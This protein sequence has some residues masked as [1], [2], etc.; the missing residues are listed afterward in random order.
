[1]FD[2]GPTENLGLSQLPPLGPVF[3]SSSK[4]T[5]GPLIFVFGQCSHLPPPQVHR[6][7]IKTCDSLWHMRPGNSRFVAADCISWG[8]FSCGR[9]CPSG[10]PR[11]IRAN[12]ACFP[13]HLH[14]GPSKPGV[15]KH[16]LVAPTSALLAVRETISGL[17]GPTPKGVNK[18]R[19]AFAADNA[20]RSPEKIARFCH[21]VARIP[22]LGAVEFY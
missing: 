3:H 19:R 18:W 15:A 13:G 10:P 20:Q 1:M 9:T 6:G 7:T 21:L 12:W 8:V 11:P 2:F 16:G 4:N 17:R 22:M 5:R 14:A